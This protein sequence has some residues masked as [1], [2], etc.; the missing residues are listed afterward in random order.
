MREDEIQDATTG[1]GACIYTS[2]AKRTS[3]PSSRFVKLKATVR[4]DEQQLDSL[5][6]VGISSP[7]CGGSATIGEPRRRHIT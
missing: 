7:S 6:R 1:S 4:K 5:T 3:S 2:S